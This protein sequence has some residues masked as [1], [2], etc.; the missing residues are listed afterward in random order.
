VNTDADNTQNK[1]TNAPSLIETMTW[2]VNNP[3]RRAAGGYYPEISLSDI[4]CEITRTVTQVG[5]VNLTD[6]RDMDCPQ[7]DV[8]DW[9]Y[10]EEDTEDEIWR[11]SGMVKQS[12]YSEL[13]TRYTKLLDLVRTVIPLVDIE[14]VEI[15]ER[16]QQGAREE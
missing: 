15:H 12:D 5:S 10:Q 9:D 7:D 6:V 8:Y 11:I 2:Q 14:A 4:E 1:T 16:T 13:M 3:I